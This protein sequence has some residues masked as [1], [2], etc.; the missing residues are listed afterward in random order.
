MS[1]KSSGLTND[2]VLALTNKMRQ[3]RNTLGPREQAAFNWV[4]AQ[5]KE[6]GGDVAG[7]DARGNP[8]DPLDDPNFPNILGL[9]FGVA[10]AGASTPTTFGAA[11]RDR[12]GPANAENR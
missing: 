4:L 7:Y 8:H 5:C 12:T 10:G 6:N 1:Q 2:E 9:R 3:F 11:N